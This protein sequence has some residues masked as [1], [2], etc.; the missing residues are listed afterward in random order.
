MWAAVGVD[1]VRDILTSKERIA[2]ASD[3]R[4]Q[5]VAG[6]VAVWHRAPVVG[7]GTGGFAV[8]YAETLTP[9]ERRHATVFVSHTAPVTV[10]A[11]LGIV[12]AAFFAWL[13]AA[14]LRV[15]S[16]RRAPRAWTRAVMG[17]ILAA[18]FTHSLLTG[19][20]ME[21]PIVWALLAAGCAVATVGPARGPSGTS[22]PVP[23][24]VPE[25]SA[26]RTWVA[27]RVGG[28]NTPCA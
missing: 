7:V 28:M 2:R 14:T 18:V 8:R 5:L 21:D 12:G 10:L 27:T 15:F 4:D 26:A 13:I 3:G 25:V 20:L 11:E 9:D 23:E 17:A 24:S 19:S 16:D 1:P 22:R 6:G